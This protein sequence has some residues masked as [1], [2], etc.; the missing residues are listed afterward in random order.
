MSSDCHSFGILNES[1]SKQRCQKRS[2]TSAHMA[3]P[4]NLYAA[5]CLNMKQI[6]LSQRKP[7]EAKLLKIWLL[8]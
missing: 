8:V 1:S 3:G 7:I 2:L 5:I 4:I 6:P